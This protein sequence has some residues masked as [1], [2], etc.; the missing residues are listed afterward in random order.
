MS[1]Q[2][3]IDAHRSN[4]RY[5]ARAVF[6]ALLENEHEPQHSLDLSIELTEKWWKWSEEFIPDGGR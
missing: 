2:E 3:Y 5:F 6:E 1:A 4:A